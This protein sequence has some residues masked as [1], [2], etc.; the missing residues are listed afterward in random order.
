MD[1]WTARRNKNSTHQWVN[2]PTGQLAD[3]EAMSP[4]T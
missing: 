2:S 3:S 4:S 1:S